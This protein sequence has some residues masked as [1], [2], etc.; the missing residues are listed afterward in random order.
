[1]YIKVV[2]Y[3][4][5]ATIFSGEA[6]DFYFMSNCDDEIQTILEEMER[7]EI[8]KGKVFRL[9]ERILVIE[10]IYEDEMEVL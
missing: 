1:M 5:M 10:S 3:E 9:E 7:V 6:E 4:T 2:D 8:G